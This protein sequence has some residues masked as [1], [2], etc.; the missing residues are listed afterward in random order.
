MTARPSDSGLIAAAA[1]AQGKGAIGII[2]LSGTGALDVGKKILD[3][4]PRIER[5]NR[6]QFLAAD[7]RIIDAGIAL[8]FRGPRSFTGEDML[9]LQ[10]HGGVAV[11]RMLLERCIELGARLAE[12]GEFSL[13]AFSNGKLDLTRAEGIADLINATSSRA[14]RLA[15]ASMSGALRAALDGLDQELLAARSGI[16]AAIDFGEDVE[17]S[18]KH[19]RELGAATRKLSMRGGELLEQCRRAAACQE[20]ASIALVGRPNAGKSTLLNLLCGEDAAIVDSQPGTTRDV[21]SKPAEIEGIA[22]M[23]HDTAGLRSGG[24]A[25]ERE[26]MRRTRRMQE[27]ADVVVAVQDAR[28]K[29]PPA[30]D[31]D[32]LVLNKI[33]LLKAKPRS[34]GKRVAMAAKTGAGLAALRRALA[35]A[36]GAAG[37]EPAFLAR[38]RHVRALEECVQELEAAARSAPA[39]LVA[40]AEHLRR[41]HGH[42][43]R[44]TGQT[45]VEDV[46]GAIFAQ[47][48]IGK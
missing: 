26:G 37:D 47:F 34:T 23:V 39:E 35:R 25:V 10:G 33:D 41:A 19:L 45:D 2:R 36:L 4:P 40:A 11:Q 3:R 27:A 38:A 15:A 22:V 6:R 18:A 20:G 32:L 28:D 8:C 7:G 44:I 21:V 24:A 31:H 16:E 30:V 14:A 1:T 13:R 12:P 46:L 42:L 29:E 48:C 43:G 17:F 9:E 5:V